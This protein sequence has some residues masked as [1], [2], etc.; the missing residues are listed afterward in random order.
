MARH[1]MT[2]L[3]ETETKLIV[4]IEPAD[5]ASA[6][7]AAVQLQEKHGCNDVL[8]T[9]GKAGCYY[10]RKADGHGAFAPP[11]PA[12][13]VDTSG[14]GDCFLGSLAFYLAKYPDLPLQEMLSRCNHIAAISVQSKGTQSSYPT[15][16]EVPPAL[17]MPASTP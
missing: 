15:R 6:A 12:V 7:A 16:A 8:I 2:G 3:N 17:L 9:L 1:H 5:E 14:A 4:G 10:R 11:C 13:A